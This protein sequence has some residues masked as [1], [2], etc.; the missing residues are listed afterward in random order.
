MNI[1]PETLLFSDLTDED[2]ASMREW[3]R[4]VIL[5]PPPGLDRESWPEWLI[6]WVEVSGL[7]D[8]QVLLML[9]SVAAARVLVSLDIHAG[10]LAERLQDER[11]EARSIAEDYRDALTFCADT[12]PL[13]WEE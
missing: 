12:G 8:R 5:G 11:D 13:P 1:D 4:R 7:D 10:Q 3:A 2:A 9:S 6:K